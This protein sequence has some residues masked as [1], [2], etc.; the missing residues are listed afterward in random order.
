MP[1]RPPNLLLL[2]TDQQRAPMHW[3][4]EPGWLDAL[5]PNDAELRRTGLTF[6]RAHT[7]TCMCSPSRATFLSGTY[8]SRH[9]VTLTLTGEALWPDPR[10]VPGVLRTAAGIA[11]SGEAPRDVLGRA[12][13]RGLLRAGPRSG[14]EAVLRRDTPTIATLLREQGYTVAYKGKWHLTHPRDPAG[15]TVADTRHLAD[16][17][18]FADW[19]PP[20]AGENALAEHFGGGSAGLTGQG[21]D[22][23]FTRQ[24]EAWLARA[25]LPEPFCLVVSLVNPHDV[26]GYPA[27][28]VAGGYDRADFAD[29]DIRLPAT[30]DEDLRDKPTAH[31]LM[32][33]GQ[34]AY[35][36]ALRG[37]EAQLDYVRFYAHLHRV[38]DEKIGRVLGALGDPGDPGS[39]RSRTVIARF[40]D[41]GEMGLSHGG[42]RQKMFNAYEET[43]RVPLVISNPVLFPRP[44]RTTALASLVD[45]VPTLAGLGGARAR[46]RTFHGVDLG[47]VLACHAAPEPAALA[48]SPVAFGP[49]LA[50]APAQTARADVLFTY[51]D[52]QA[53]TALQEVAP[54][55]NRIRCVS[56]GDW[57]YSMYIDPAGTAAPQHELYDLRSDPGEAHNLA[58]VDT[59]RGRTDA[60]RREL[61]GLHERLSEACRAAEYVLP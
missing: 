23:D 49:A 51:D 18:G 37:R 20:D 13:L 16:E 21:W 54:Q 59:G 5:A 61:P 53:G 12:F 58:E 40:S 45:V 57:K 48:A 38:I 42:L 11:G 41:H 10:N 15:W 30:V 36:G 28:D 29:L 6:E 4:D 56:D 31:A 39:L 25:S 60:A 8:P 44:A 19:E 32:R 17:L 46:G 26:L 22:E 1:Q 47:P 7:A 35:L 34:N 33:L 50:V 14:H 3:P 24:T 43:I 55:P 2:V 27:C 52:H 9:G